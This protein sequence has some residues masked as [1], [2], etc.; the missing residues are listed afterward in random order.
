M[1]S[2]CFLQQNTQV[3]QNLSQQT[4]KFIKKNIKKTSTTDVF[5]INGPKMSQVL[6]HGLHPRPPR[7]QLLALRLR[8]L[9]W[10]APKHRGISQK[11]GWISPSILGYPHL[12]W[13][14]PIYFGISPSIWG[15]P[16]LFWDIPIYLGISPSIWGYPHLFGDIPIY[17]GI[18]S[19]KHMGISQKYGWRS[20]SILGYPQIDVPIYLGIS[21]K[22]HMEIGQKWSNG[23]LYSWSDP[24][25]QS[26]LVEFHV[27]L[28]WWCWATS[29]GHGIATF[30]ILIIRSGKSLVGRDVHWGRKLA[31]N[32]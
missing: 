24:A 4:N 19:K 18:S 9:A 25:N 14:I 26:R 2:G 5:H 30:G 22:K 29:D 17:L 20:S 27:I 10:T 28:G 1:I 15:Y 8:G 6:H 31:C 11:Y 3:I 16:H 23:L 13:D 7:L 21:S 12:F 32:K